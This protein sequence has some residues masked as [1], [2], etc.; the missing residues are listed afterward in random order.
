MTLHYRVH[1]LLSGHRETRTEQDIERKKTNKSL[2]ELIHIPYFIRWKALVRAGDS[3][4]LLCG[5]VSWSE[6]A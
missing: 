1:N 5:R 3:L 4:L 2:K 6:E